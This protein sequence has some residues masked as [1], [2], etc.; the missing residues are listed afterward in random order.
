MNSPKLVLPLVLLLALFGGIWLIFNEQASIEEPALSA[1]DSSLEI[2]VAESSPDPAE[3]WVTGPGRIETGRAI[4]VLDPGGSP[5]HGVEVYLKLD[6]DESHYEEFSKVMG[7]LDEL[8][9]D[10]S[11]AHFS[12]AKRVRTNEK[13]VAPLPDSGFGFAFVDTGKMGN[14]TLVDK[15]EQYQGNLVVMK[16]RAYSFIEVKVVEANGKPAS[17]VQVEL[18]LLS[19][20]K[21]PIDNFPRSSF[22]YGNLAPLTDEKGLTY[23]RTDLDSQL[24][25]RQ[26]LPQDCNAYVLT[27]NNL[28]KPVRKR[29][30]LKT[31]TSVKLQLPHSG[32]VEVTLLNATSNMYP[33]L[34]PHST[35]NNQRHYSTSITPPKYRGDNGK[36]RF[37]RV[38]LNQEFLLR[39]YRG[40]QTEN[41]SSSSSTDLTGPIF[42]GPV[43]PTQSVEVAMDLHEHAWFAGS[44]VDD[45]RQPIQAHPTS[46][47]FS[48]RAT[49]GGDSQQAVELTGF[50]G[51]Q[52]DFLVMKPEANQLEFLQLELS[53]LVIQK[54]PQ[55]MTWGRSPDPREPPTAATAAI[56]SGPERGLTNLGQL[57]IMP[58]Q[59]LLTVTVVNTAGEPIAYPRLRVSY[60]RVSDNDRIQKSG[61][62]MVSASYQGMGQDW[63]SERDGTIKAYGPSWSALANAVRRYGSRNK[64]TH[65]QQLQLIVSADGYLEQEMIIPA[66]QMQATVT[67]QTAGEIVGTVMRSPKFRWLEVAALAPGEPSNPEG[68]QRRWPIQ[69]G[70]RDEDGNTSNTAEFRIP[71]LVPSDY[72]IVFTTS[73]EGG[74]F[75]RIPGVRVGEG[76]NYDPRLQNLDLLPHLAFVQIK[77]FDTN[78]NAFTTEQ[79]REAGGSTSR[80]NS[81]WTGGNGRGWTIHEDSV[82][83]EMAKDTTLNAKVRMNGH[84]QLRIDGWKAGIYEW[85]PHSTQPIHLKIANGADFPV[86]TFPIVSLVALSD[87]SSWELKSANRGHV[88][89]K[90]SIP[91][92]GNYLLKIQSQTSPEMRID[93]MNL[94]I[95]ASAIGGN[96]PVEISLTQQQLN[97]FQSQR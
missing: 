59:P 20:D 16:L 48:F 79:L 10:T 51:H 18:A 66:E 43:S 45:Q 14:L 91:G 41:G 76:E 64:H 77:V 95:P 81:T 80:W 75:L 82:W 31:T 85:Q 65:I 7:R 25:K 36:W 29:I 28:S 44:L 52:G 5:V 90:G 71:N 55:V 2:S 33:V 12:S 73:N 96:I 15:P 62:A 70:I 72:D 94:Q 57:Q 35:S 86:G 26:V 68:N 3:S 46:R 58:M 47:E 83:I 37:P 40:E 78:G 87:Y 17:G 39:I 19:K 34:V 54:T 42:S 23:L 53:T 84:G 22:S 24:R 56:P 30:D 92:Y 38:P 60:Q 69:D 21:D 93:P 63:L 8:R 88:N 97:V 67:L 32:G 61:W 89:W 11:L 1:E 27:R 13:G 4:Q 50:I 74:E 49:T 9:A 6:D